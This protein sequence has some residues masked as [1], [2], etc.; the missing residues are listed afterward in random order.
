MKT[1]ELRLN[2]LV[3]LSYET[4]KGVFDSCHIDDTNSLLNDEAFPVDKLYSDGCELLI[5]A[6][7]IEFS[8][9][10]IE[11]ILLTEEWLLKLGFEPHKSID[12]SFSHYAK[13]VFTYNTNHG[14][15]L[16]S[17]RLF[18]QSRLEYVHQLQNLFYAITG[19]D[20]FLNAI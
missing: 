8:I 17:Q 19:K 18:D 10:E 2:N 14:W 7:D 4:R 12:G 6:E 20:V 5:G 13:D 11:P 16:F 15:W 9:E 1:E 3:S